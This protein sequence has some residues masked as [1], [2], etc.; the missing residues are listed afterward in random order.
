MDD[1]VGGAVASVAF[2][3]GTALG[4]NDATALPVC[5]GDND[6]SACLFHDHTAE[7]GDG[8][9]FVSTP[10]GAGG[11]DGMT[12]LA[13]CLRDKVASDCR[14]HD[15]VAED[16]DGF[17]FVPTTSVGGAGT[18]E[19]PLVAATRTNPLEGTMGDV[20]TVPGCFK[21]S[22][23]IIHSGLLSPEVA[24]SKVLCF[25][26]SRRAINSVLASSFS[27]GATCDVCGPDAADANGAALSEGDVAAPFS[28]ARRF[29]ASRL[30]IHSGL[31][32]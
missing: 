1:V 31:L 2:S 20:G 19:A 6:A 3:D 14:F 32:G 30:S 15:Q 8:F 18:T 11:G 27:S 16:G 5:L 7:D 28:D 29:I 26:L 17:A 4:G 9:V 12:P 13:D 21:F 23:L 24:P 22:R 25:K 10:S